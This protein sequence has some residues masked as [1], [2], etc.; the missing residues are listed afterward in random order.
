MKTFGTIDSKDYSVEE[1]F[2]SSPMSWELVSSSNG[3]QIT[4]PD[5]LE[6]AI[7]FDKCSKYGSA[8]FNSYSEINEYYLYRSVKHLF[9]TSPAV[10]YNSTTLLTSSLAP[11]ADNSYVI[12]ISQ[13]FYG[14]RI[15]PGS[16]EL[17]T[18]LSNKYIRDDGYGNLFVSQ[19][20]T[21]SY[22]GNIFYK[23]GIIVI[24]EASGS[25]ITTLSS[26]GLKIVDSTEIYLDYSSDVEITRHEVNVNVLPTDFNFSIFNPTILSTYTASGSF[27]NAFISS[28]G[29]RN[30]R[31]AS[32]SSTW[33]LYNLMSTGVIKPYITSIGLYNEQNQLLAVAKFSE[34]IQRTFDTNQIFIIRFDT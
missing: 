13:N 23:N 17:S 12:S 16:F 21:G 3:I 24:K 1:L 10:F 20:S 25:T 32:G 9:Y 27:G 26:A 15:K 34:P 29:D 28:M 18:E 30:I 11:L 33:N 31:P 2:V 6:G 7:V 5:D 4:V 14:E 19:S 22:V 8:S